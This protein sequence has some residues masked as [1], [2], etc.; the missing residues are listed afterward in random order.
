MTRR[1]SEL[2][3]QLESGSQSCLAEVDNLRFDKKALEK[4]LR[5]YVTHCQSLM[6]D[7]ASM[8]DALKACNVPVESDSDPN[9]A[10]IAL[11]D[12]YRE[13]K[14]THG[15]SRGDAMVADLEKK[16]GALVAK[17]KEV[18]DLERTSSA[19]A[20]QYQKEIELVKGALH[21]TKEDLEET[22]RASK[23]EISTL[24][25]EAL[26][27]ICEKK[28]VKK[29]LQN[30]QAEL[31]IMR[32]N[33]SV[34]NPTVDF[35]VSDLQLVDSD[36]DSP[37]KPKLKERTAP[38]QSMPMPR[39]ETRKPLGDAT[40]GSG[41]LKQSGVIIS[42]NSNRNLHQQIEKPVLPSTSKTG[43][44]PGLGEAGDAVMYEDENTQECKQS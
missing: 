31:E 1:N 35:S 15:S 7:K 39:K 18:E 24:K 2:L 14:R 23:R 9:D 10:V 12:K 25:E 3:E 30:V 29:K 11:C 26:Q 20:T 19:R 36:D 38:T 37:L 40:N 41:K 4:K 27:A 44:A 5:K 28:A 42:K 22:K 43:L 6:D 17:I 13:A 32:M 34:D 21:H 16:I 33:A 8:M